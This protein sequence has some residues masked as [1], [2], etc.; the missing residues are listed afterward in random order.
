MQSNHVKI[1]DI[2]ST[3][4]KIPDILTHSH[5]VSHLQTGDTLKRRER[6]SDRF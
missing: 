1:L 4:A 3:H 2:Q 5:S 6:H